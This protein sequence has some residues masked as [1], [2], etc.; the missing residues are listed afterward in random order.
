MDK[1]NDTLLARY[2]G[3]VVDALPWQQLAAPADGDPQVSG[4]KLPSWRRMLEVSA[5]PCLLRHLS[6]QGR[7]VDSGGWQTS[8][9]QR[10]QPVD[11]AHD[12]HLG[13]K[14]VQTLDVIP[15]PLSCWALGQQSD[16]VCCLAN[17]LT[18]AGVGATN[19][20]AF[21]V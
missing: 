7:V 11:E 12:H 14:G 10:R 9:H 2:D 20:F 4:S 18:K 21:P 13:G 8:S 6:Y 5:C 15:W 17:L 19:C 3:S 16:A 1:G